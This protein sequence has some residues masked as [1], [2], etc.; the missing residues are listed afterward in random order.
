MDCS[1]GLVE[2][3]VTDAETG[4]FPRRPQGAAGASY[5]SSVDGEEFRLD[6]QRDAE[7][8]R[9]WI[10]ATPGRCFSYA[11]GERVHFGDAELAEVASEAP[12]GTLVRI[13]RLRCTIVTGSGALSVGWIR[14]EDGNLP[15]AVWCRKRGL[16]AGVQL[17]D[18]SATHFIS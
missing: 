12:A 2:R 10:C 1:V 17:G 11:A 15:A 16:K 5:F 4:A 7:L 6:W 13:G 14:V 8:L 18:D 9:R 3:L